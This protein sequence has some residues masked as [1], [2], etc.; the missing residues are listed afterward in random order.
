MSKI[1][2]IEDEDQV[3]E[4]IRQI[5]EM[6][7]FEVRV[8][9]LGEKGVTLAQQ[10]CPNLIICD[11]MMPGID[12]YAVL[13]Q[14]RQ[15][16]ATSRVPFIFLTAKAEHGDRRFG[17]GL[18]ADDY[19]TKPF[20]PRELLQAVEAR[21]SRHAILEN[22]VRDIEQKSKSLK[23]ALQA[24]QQQAA[25]SSKLADLKDDLLRKLSEDLRKP[26]S[27]INMAIE[28]LR[29]AKSEEE[30]DRY[31][32]VLKEEYNREMTLLSQVDDLQSLLTPANARLL[33][34]LKL[35]ERSACLY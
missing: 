10:N 19:L 21:L 27:N 4:N 15:Y 28:M 30:R 12:G 5:L 17:M 20:E 31:I 6:S 2:V 22:H 33:Q 23:Q 24:N 11:I 25:E 3:R 14:L 35:F 29:Q 13:Q 32:S 1:L 7:G 8:A 9:E 18:G 26:L 16:P 34:S